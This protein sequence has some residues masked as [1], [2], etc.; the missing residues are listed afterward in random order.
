MPL[1]VRT[2]SRA[3]VRPTVVR[4]SRPVREADI[5]VP[6]RVRVGVK[7]SA[8]RCRYAARVYL[9]CLRLDRQCRRAVRR[10]RTGGRASRTQHG[11]PHRRILDATRSRPCVHRTGHW[12]RIAHGARLGATRKMTARC[13]VTASSVKQPPPSGPVQIPACARP[14]GRQ[15]SGQVTLRVPIRVWR[16]PSRRPA[17]SVTHHPPAQRRRGHDLETGVEE[18]L[19]Q[20]H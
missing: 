17:E 15:P 19:Q 14:G 20:P 10:A 9:V 7:E 13:S 11:I 5:L 2:I 4:G 16:G 18:D 3:D 6:T 12:A 1:R 8:L